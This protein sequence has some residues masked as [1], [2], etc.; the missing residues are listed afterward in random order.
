MAQFY[1]DLVYT[2]ALFASVPNP[3]LIPP[4]LLPV[5]YDWPWGYATLENLDAAGQQRVGGGF[6]GGAIGLNPVLT[7][8]S[9]PVD[10]TDCNGS[11]NHDF[12]CSAFM[13]LGVTVRFQWWKDDKKLT[14]LDNPN[15]NKPVLSFGPLT[16]DMA[17]IYK[18]QVFGFG[19]DVQWTN[20]V[21]MNV[22]SPVKITRQPYSTNADIGTSVMF[23]VEAHAVMDSLIN[24][25]P[26]FSPEY[27]WYRNDTLILS[28]NKHYSGQTTSILSIRDVA[29]T[30]YSDNYTVQVTAQCG[31]DRSQA[32]SLKPFPGVS[33]TGQPTNTTKCATE[34]VTLTVEASATNGGTGL[35]YQWN[36]G[37]VPIAGANQSTL[38]IA[39][40]TT[41]DAGTYNCTVTAI[42]G[43]KQVQSASAV[44]TIN[45]K[46][47]ITT[48]PAKTMDVKTTKSFTIA[49]DA[50]GSDLIT[51]QWFKDNNKMDGKT[52][53][54]LTVDSAKLSDAGAYYC[55]VKNDC[56]T[57]PNSDTTVVTVTTEDTNP[58]GVDETTAGGFVLNQN[59]PNPFNTTTMVTFVTTKE[60]SVKL[61]V[62]DL[63]G[64][65]L[66]VLINGTV[67]SGSHDVKLNSNE[68]KLST[69]L[70]YITLTAEGYTL[71]KKMAVVR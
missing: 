32:F 31:T 29:S 59:T 5:L 50:S 30:D 22:L 27:K 44:V 46:P 62:T 24:D 13:T 11:L 12:R 37:G 51:Y 38:T 26:L 47:T 36:K 23:E 17:G 70:Y 66:S 61:S 14:A 18:C 43:D 16:Y 69:G 71:T 64:R 10:I 60:T 68:L 40:A 3:N 52:G 28:T 45:V 35:S 6:F 53:K 63:F 2:R 25:P 15:Y 1:D 20:P 4:T 34:T 56:G 33:I 8:L 49:I 48:H 67:S 7:L 21:R 41:G 19:S 57:A 58:Q 55:E 65:E 9:Q 42:P 39:N 54:S